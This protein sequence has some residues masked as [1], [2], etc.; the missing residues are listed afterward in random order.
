M[1]IENVVEFIDDD[2]SYLKWLDKNPHGFVINTGRSKSHSYMVLHRASCR[3]IWAYSGRA[4]PGAFTQHDYIKI[5]AP[6]I[7]SLRAWVRRH[8]RTDGSF[9]SECTIGKPK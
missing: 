4:Q 6:D 8:G 5:C 2:R 9:S 1:A 7:A 3:S